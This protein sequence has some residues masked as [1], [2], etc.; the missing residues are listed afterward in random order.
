MKPLEGAIALVT[1][2]TRGLGKGIAT[3]L[4]E[5]GATV[6]ITGRTLTATA[7]SVGSLEETAAAIAQGGRQRHPRCR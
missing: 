6:Y 2:G 7:D 5:A 4:G 3:G 1:G